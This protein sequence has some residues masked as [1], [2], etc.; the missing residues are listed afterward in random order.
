MLAD[1]RDESDHENQTRLVLVPRSNRVDVD[2]LMSH[3]FA[4][5]DLEKS[6][7]VNLN[8]IGLNLR[9]Q[10]KNLAVLIKEWLSYRVETV[11]R[12]LQFRL[13]KINERL[14]I[15]DG[16]L[17]A[18]LNLDEVIRIIREEETPKDALRKKFKLT[19]IQA[20]AI[21]DLRLRQLAKLEE[22]KLNADKEELEGEKADL[23]KT[24]KSKARLKTLVKKELLTDAKEYGDPR[25]SQFS[26]GE[27][28]VAF[29][30]EDLISNE[31]ITVVLS[32]KGWIRAARGHDADPRELSYRGG[33]KYS[34]AARG[35][36]NDILVF[37]D[38][39]GRSYTVAPHTLP[40]AR[41]QGEP[42]TG[43]FKPAA[44]ARFV[45]L[46]MGSSSTRVLLAS[47]AGYGFIGSLDEMT[48][49]NRAGKACLSVPKG[50]TSLS[51]VMVNL[52]RE[53]KVVAVTN[54]G[55]MLIFPLAD[56]P[57]L[58]RGKGNK[59]L[60]VPSKA[61]RAG[62]EFLVAVAV[63]GQ[64]DD[65]LVLAGLRHLRMKSKDLENYVGERA[66]RGRKLPRGF[67]RVDSLAV[68]S[69]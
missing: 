64:H 11:R 60:N 35:R 30:K 27:T 55:R 4:S 8:I 69:R 36:T 12:R 54:T 66:R 16:L 37:L 33:D 9:P 53:Q 52:E 63:I 32:E 44:G 50:G 59:L 39:F 18:Y 5:T 47:N 65:L 23:E 7:R 25:R 61:F 2:R 68:E 43:R 17:N 41:G 34:H 22:I 56:V 57:E 67:Q 15:L 31:P 13:E 20:N 45:G 10:V 26:D 24:L 62:E 6:Y 3:L 21:L 51:P 42:L 1:L 14:H 19:D 46:A 28:A 29:S 58:S 40:S 38:S 48:T 49:K